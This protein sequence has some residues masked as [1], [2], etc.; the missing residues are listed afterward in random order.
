[1]HTVCALAPP[2]NTVMSALMPIWIGPWR[3]PVTPQHSSLY[4]IRVQLQPV[5]RAS[6]A[7]AALAVST[8]SCR[9]AL[10]PLLYPPCLQEE[11]AKE[12]AALIE[13]AQATPK[14]DKKDVGGGIATLPKGYVPKA[15]EAAWYDW[16]ERCGFFKPEAVPASTSGEP[17]DPFVIVIPPPNV[18]GIL[19]IGHALTQAIEVGGRDGWGLLRYG[20]NVLGS[21]KQTMTH[22]ATGMRACH[23]CQSLSL[24]WTAHCI[25]Q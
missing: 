1:M 12:Q 22:C 23:A 4:S 24:D 8:P 3:P 5:P 17:K 7:S 19:H 25:P 9:S 14:G 21:H 15:V 6:C 13:R 11:E 2:A 18:T 20:S 10:T 16:W